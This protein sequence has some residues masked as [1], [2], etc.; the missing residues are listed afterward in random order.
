MAVTLDAFTD[1]ELRA[2]LRRREKAPRPKPGEYR[3]HRCPNRADGT[4]R[5]VCAPDAPMPG[6]CVYLG[7]CPDPDVDRCRAVNAAP[8]A[9]RSIIGNLSF[10]YGDEGKYAPYYRGMYLPVPVHP[11]MAFQSV[12][13][14]KASAR[15]AGIEY[16]WEA[17]F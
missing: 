17:P 12:A 13:A 16:T 14:E 10:T 6:M 2:E 3:M 7:P 5:I 1:D 4:G 15:A 8:G 9:W 11:T